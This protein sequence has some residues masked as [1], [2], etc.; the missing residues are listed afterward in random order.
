HGFASFPDSPRLAWTCASRHAMP[1]GMA[2]LFVF[3]QAGT[4]PVKSSFHARLLAP[5]TIALTLV[6]PCAA[7]QPD[8]A[9]PPRAIATQ[10]PPAWLPRYDVAMQVD[11]AG[12]MVRVQQRVT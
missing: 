6:F 1:A 8:D 4:F 2:A 7:A 3:G 9:P 10:G 11:V 12:H 5:L